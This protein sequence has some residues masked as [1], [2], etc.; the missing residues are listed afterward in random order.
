MPYRYYPVHV[1]EKPGGRPTPLATCTLL[2]HNPPHSEAGIVVM[3][4][5]WGN[6]AARTKSLSAKA[7][8]CRHLALIADAEETRQGYLRLARSYDALAED[9]GRANGRPGFVLAT[10]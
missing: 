7:S 2:P 8:E 3:R 6:A 5:R 1:V 9:A 4:W 10:S